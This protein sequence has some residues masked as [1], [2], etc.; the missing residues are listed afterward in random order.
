MA[1]P[2]P[3]D[4]NRVWTVEML[5]ELPDDG[6]R[7]EIVDGELLVSPLPSLPHQRAAQELGGLLHAYARRVGGVE[8]FG[9]PIS[10]R[11]SRT[12]ELQPD[13]SIIRM[14]DGKP[15]QRWEEIGCPL[16]VVEVLS[17]STSRNDRFTKRR[18]YLEQGVDE[19][20]LL[21]LEDRSIERWRPGAE[22]PETIRDTISWRVT[23]TSASFDLDLPA[24]FASVLGE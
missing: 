18:K 3:L 19:Y 10:A 8:A 20:W 13:V 16:L 24:F 11:F 21:D 15:A 12:T 5:D 17:P 14:V 2:A 22:F 4:L 1:M 7:Y 9:V 6:K 23:P